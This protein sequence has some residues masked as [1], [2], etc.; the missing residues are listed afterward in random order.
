MEVDALTKENEELKRRVQVL[1]NQLKQAR[2]EGVKSYFPLIESKGYSNDTTDKNSVLTIVVLGASGDLAKKKTFPALY[3]L[4]RRGLF[5]KEFLVIGYARTPMDPAKFKH[6]ITQNLKGSSENKEKFASSAHYVAGN[7]NSL[8]DFQ[9]LSDEISNF[10]KKLHPGASSNRVFY[11]ALP[12]VVFVDAA[13]AIKSKALSKSGW[14]RV[15]VEKPFGRDLNSFRVM[16]REL[17]AIFNEDEIYRIDHYLGK[18]MVQN[19]M[20]LRFANS[21]FEPLWNHRYISSVTITFKENFGTEG[22]GGYFDEFGII[23]DVM[24]NH[25]TQIL[26]LVAMESPVSL[27]AEDIRDEKVKVLRAIPAVEYKDT[28]LGQYGRDDKGKNPSYLD[29]K[30]VP[31][32]SN[33]PTFAMAVLHIHNSRWNG[34]PFILKCGKALDERKAEVRVQFKDVTA[35]LFT[36]SPRNELV[37]RLQPKEAIYM[38]TNIK[39]PGLTSELVQTELDLT[40]D[41]RFKAAEEGLPDAYERLILDVTRGDHN[42]FVRAD[43]LDAAWKIFTP[44]LHHIES[45]K[46]KPIIYPFG[47]RG[48]SEADELAKKY[49]YVRHSNYS[50]GSKM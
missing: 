43:E 24:Q 44:L 15:I 23:R 11:M 46:V 4:F 26:S 45:E 20:A 41:D 16:S 38:K 47:S 37:L 36:D 27:A 12:P 13:K 8:D 1:E 22:R 28:V 33:C 42:L 14:N 34:V 50:W 49:G 10:E 2:P 19:L 21:V 7:Y 17:S 35:N 40:Y 3:E 9:K 39:V 31:K 32:G 48:P 18:E 30:T 29:D 6:H 25:L 5:P